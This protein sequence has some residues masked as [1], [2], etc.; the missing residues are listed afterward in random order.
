MS[1]PNHDEARIRR[2]FRRSLIAIATAIF[3]G[4]LILLGRQFTQPEPTP[5]EPRETSG[6]SNLHEDTVTAPDLVFTDVTSSAG[7]DF[8]H[9]SGAY[10]ERLLPET[11]GGGVA[12]LDFDNDGH[13]DIV[14]VNSNN[15]PWEKTRGPSPRSRLYRNNGDGTFKDVTLDVG[16]DVRLYGMGV[17]VGDY[18]SDGYVDI[19]ISAYGSNKL[20]RNIRGTRFEDATLE[21]GVA[22]ENDA[23]S[24]SSAFFDFDHDQDLDLFVTNYVGWS[25]D[26]DREVDYRLTG[27]GRAYGPP[28]DFSGTNSY[29]YRNDD[30]RFIDV[31]RDAGITVNQ[32]GS[33]LAVGKG[34]AVVPVDINNDGWLDLAVAN[35]TVRNFLFI[36]QKNGRFIEEGIEYGFA[37]DSAGLATG[38]MGIDATRDSVD[39]SLSVAIGN[40]AN[41]MS[42]FY[43]L[44]NDEDVFSDN[45]IVTGIGADSR[46]ALTFGLVFFDADLDGAPDLLATNGHVEPEINRVQASQQYRQPVQLFWNCQAKCSRPYQLARNTGDL[47]FARA[48]RGAAY[49]DIDGD[50]DLDVILTQVGDKASL[51]QN[52]LASENH[53]VRLKLKSNPP[54]RNA[55]GATV[56]LFTPKKRWVRTVMP[57]RSYLSQVELP[58]TFGLG[59]AETIQRVVVR[60]PD[61]VSEEWHDLEIDRLHVLL[62][63]T[64][65][66]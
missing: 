20:L 45:A 43:V 30:G 31:T 49:A 62:Q 40:F 2:A 11:M 14:L 8:R 6:P 52:D 5:L 1:D 65:Q 21:A 10:G 44:R 7:I 36:N 22:G 19:F 42:S 35:D 39:G 27:I 15:W 12:F 26:I 18:D 33:E 24:T 50:G 48:G 55:I 25:R 57:T 37:F 28:T 51:L 3:L 53:W 60:W 46:R 9:V 56:G 13:Q 4:L 61:G 66:P 64:A 16:F 23:W 54:N 59:P 29:L 63:G 17:A 47:A 34:L 58:L 38:A 41:E 32:E